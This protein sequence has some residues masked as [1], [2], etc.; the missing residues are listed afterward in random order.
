M[1]NINEIINKLKELKPSLQAE[2]KIT[3]LGV[4]GSFARNE[5]TQNSDIDILIDY[6]DGTSILTLGGLQYALSEIFGKKVDIVMKKSLKRNIGKQILSE[7][8]Y[9]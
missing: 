1:T 3:E 8:L 7:V 9:V 6:E 4:F 2:F 5:Q